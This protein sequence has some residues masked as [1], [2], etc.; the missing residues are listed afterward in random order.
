VVVVRIVMDNSW[1]CE[2]FDDFGEFVKGVYD[3]GKLVIVELV[4]LAVPWVGED[5][6]IF[7]KDRLRDN[8][9]A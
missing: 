5:T 7:P 2:R 1:S 9:H 6:G 4:D 8:S 3:V